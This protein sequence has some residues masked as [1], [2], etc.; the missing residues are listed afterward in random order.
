MR[1]ITVERDNAPDLIFEGEKIASATSQDRSRETGRWTILRLYK[2]KSGKFVCHEIG[3]T[4]WQGERE[5][6]RAGVFEL[7]S[8]VVGFFGY[9]WLAKE[10][11]GEAEINAVEEIT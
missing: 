3:A 10:L 5:R 2:T 4:Q 11:Y 9:G 6:N 7:E 8:D 1:K